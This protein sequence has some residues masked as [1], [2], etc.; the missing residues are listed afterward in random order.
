MASNTGQRFTVLLSAEGG[1][2]LLILGRFEQRLVGRDW[3][4]DCL[5]GM[6]ELN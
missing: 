2:A 4:Q 3:Y 1:R 5:V 6:E